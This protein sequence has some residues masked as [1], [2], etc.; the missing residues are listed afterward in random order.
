MY[1]WVSAD[2][3]SDPIETLEKR[4]ALVDYCVAND[5]TLVLLDMYQYLGS[6]NDTPTHRTR[7]RA[8]LSALNVEGIETHA[9]AGAPDWIEP[10]TLPWIQTNIIDKIQDFNTTGTSNQRFAGMHFD[11]EYWIDVGTDVV[12]ALTGTKAVVD[13]FRATTG[14]PAGC[15]A[16]SFILDYVPSRASVL[17]DGT[18][19][20]DGR[21]MCDFSDY[22]IVGTYADSGAE[23]IQ[24]MN[25]WVT[26]ADATAGVVVWASSE[27]G[28]LGDISYWGGSKATMVAQQAILVAE[29]PNDRAFGGVAV[30]DYANWKLLV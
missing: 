30:Q 11:I 15:F 14:L 12:H 13:A 24:L 16:P 20:Q 25:A 29:Y 6:S 18:T 5:V 19:K 3:A 22:V 7:M 26:Y 27:T 9:L 1:V 17:F 2:T 8:L 23:Q 10:G 4:T 28:D 21:H